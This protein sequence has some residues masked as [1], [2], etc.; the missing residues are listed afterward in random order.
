MKFYF[1]FLFVVIVFIIDQLQI[2]SFKFLTCYS[3]GNVFILP[4]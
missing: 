3:I 4:N 1:I 2:A